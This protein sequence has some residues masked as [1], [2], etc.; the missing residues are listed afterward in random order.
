MM[1]AIK[2]QMDCSQ[3]RM[4]SEEHFEEFRGQVRKL[5]SN[6]A[7]GWEEIPFTYYHFY[8][9]SV[10]E[11]IH[12]G[13]YFYELLLIYFRRLYER[14]EGSLE[15]TQEQEEDAS[16]LLSSQYH[17]FEALFAQDVTYAWKLDNMVFID[18]HEQFY[19]LQEVW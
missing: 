4:I 18:V 19:P 2:E 16:E 13:D 15:L 5:Y 11:Q 10:D 7:N 8:A 3:L 14:T 6:M 1:V 12:D 17:Y 9:K